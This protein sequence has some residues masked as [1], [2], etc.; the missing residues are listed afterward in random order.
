MQSLPGEQHHGTVCLG[1]LPDKPVGQPVWIAQPPEG[2]EPR[3]ASINV[4]AFWE[5]L[6]PEERNRL[7]RLLVNKVET[8]TPD[9]KIEA[10]SSLMVVLPLLPS[11]AITGSWKRPRQAG[12]DHGDTVL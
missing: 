1:G 5:D 11:T 9:M 4:G 10:A 12:V 2:G 3:K 6:F 7:I 8:P